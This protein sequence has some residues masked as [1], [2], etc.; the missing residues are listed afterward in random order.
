[1][2][3]LKRTKLL[4]AG[5]LAFGI[6]FGTSFAGGYAAAAAGGA[7]SEGTGADIAG[8]YLDEEGEDYEQ[9][10]KALYE[11]YASC[12]ITRKNGSYYYKDKRIKVIKDCSPG[13]SVYR[14]D[15]KLKGTAGIKVAR[16][17]KGSIKRVSYM[18]RKEAERLIKRAGLKAD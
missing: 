1:M 11:E 14:F 12:G 18:T 3:F 10:E 2:D 17:E 5:L 16:D 4:M 13:Y 9:D 15:P 8:G 6:V 7:G